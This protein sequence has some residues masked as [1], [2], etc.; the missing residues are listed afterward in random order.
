MVPIAAAFIKVSLPSPNSRKK[1]VN[2]P[3]AVEELS[4]KST[5]FLAHD[6]GETWKDETGGA[7]IATVLVFVFE[8]PEVSVTVN[9]V[10]N[11]PEEEYL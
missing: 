4:V 9:V 8:H 11:D 6:C 2:V 3:L 10:I 1:D 7:K 5:G